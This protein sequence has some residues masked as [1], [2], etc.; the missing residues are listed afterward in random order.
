MK[1]FFK[2]YEFTILAILLVVAILGSA[3]I[4][5]CVSYDNNKVNTN[6]YC[7]RGI[8]TEAVEDNYIVDLDNGHRFSFSSEVQFTIDTVVN[9]CFDMGKTDA[10]E[11]D[12]IIAVSIDNYALAESL[13]DE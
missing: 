13:F 12:I 8:I 6:T 7:S 5:C 9:V 10:V 2:K 11:D 4:A 3:A 1:K